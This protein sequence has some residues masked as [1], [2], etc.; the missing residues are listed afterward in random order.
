[1]YVIL[2]LCVFPL[3]DVAPGGK[4]EALGLPFQQ[5]ARFVLEHEDEVTESEQQTID[6]MLGYN[7]LTERYKPGWH[8]P[9]KYGMNLE[10]DT[11]DLLS[12]L[13]VWVA[14]GLRHPETYMAVFMET[15]SP[16]LL[17]G[18]TINIHRDTGDVEHSGSP[19]V[20]RPE[21]LNEYHEFMMNLYDAESKLPIVGALFQTWLYATVIPLLSFVVLLKRKSP[22]L[23]CYAAVLVSIAACLISPMFDARYALPLIYTSPLLLGL[24]FCGRLRKHV[25]TNQTKPI[26]GNIPSLTSSRSGR[27]REEGNGLGSRLGSC[28]RCQAAIRALPRSSPGH[29][30]K[31]ASYRRLQ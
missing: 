3:L 15:A 23:P 11:S 13:R 6:K 9:V 12:Y 16:Y 14:Q 24:A 4:Q 20:W 18:G 31:T 10:S 2:P 22:I 25:R 19:L 27:A 29:D 5:T 7:D 26:P 8:D 1:M 17:P 28:G 30:S 21:R